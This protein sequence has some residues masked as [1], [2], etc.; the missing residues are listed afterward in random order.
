MFA[1]DGDRLTRPG[2]SACIRQNPMTNHPL[3]A[4]AP[5]CRLDRPS[6]GGADE[7][8]IREIATGYLNLNFPPGKFKV[9]PYKSLPFSHKGYIGAVNY[10]WSNSRE[11]PCANPDG[12]CSAGGRIY[13]WRARAR[14]QALRRRRLCR[15]TPSFTTGPSVAGP[16][17]SGSAIGSTAQIG[18]ADTGAHGTRRA[19][20]RAAQKVPA[21]QSDLPEHL[22]EK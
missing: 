22:G 16:G 17:D 8:L 6:R 9:I 10:N 18:A 4:F 11:T 21:P 7:T 2:R 13:A 12:D 15:S 20:C 14:P 19:P 5:P 3:V 1:Y